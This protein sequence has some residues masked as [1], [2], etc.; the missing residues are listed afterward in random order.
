MPAKDRKPPAARIEMIVIGASAGG[1]DGVLTIV[2]QLPASFPACVAIVIHN[3]GRS[4]LPAILARVSELPVV[5]PENGDAIVPGR[6]VVAPHDHHLL[7]SDRTFTL[8]S[9]PRENGFRPAIDPL[10]RTAARAYGN[11]VMAILLSGSQDDGT[12]G[13]QV[14]KNAGGLTVVQH[15]EEAA[16]RS[17]PLSAIAN[18]DVDHVAT[19]AAIVD[20]I[21]ERSG[22]TSRKGTT[23]MAPPETLEP[24][25]PAN[26]TPV[27]AMIDSF[28]LPS[29]ITC[30]D[31][32]GALWEIRDGQ[33]VRYRCH[34][35]HQYSPERLEAG[36]NDAVEGAL[37]SAVRALEEQ[38]DLRQRMA[39]RAQGSH[40]GSVRARFT[41]AALESRR[42]AA[43][44]RHL[45]FGR[46]APPE[47]S[48]NIPQPR[49]AKRRKARRPASTA[50]RARRTNGR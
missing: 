23:I 17:M 29:G 15:P 34:V 14:I 7:V 45:L 44:I 21:I 22:P 16:V 1:L 36:Q 37:W 3:N 32:G 13:M 27:K 18:V 6:I 30:P 42:Q 20:L 28:G 19:V 38:A 9:G 24:Q 8:H 49:A 11:K 31:C 2:R 12:Y 39:E 26:A 43:S 10:F 33:L 47:E 25:D 35:G 46:P 41:D 4:H 5:V 48:A 50:P 40:L